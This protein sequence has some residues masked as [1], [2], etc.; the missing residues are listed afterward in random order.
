MNDRQADL[1]RFYRILDALE[2]RIGGERTLDQ[3]SGKLAWP[4]RGVY[5]FR[6]TGETRSDCGNGSRI[7][8]VGTHGLKAGSGT[9]LWTRLRPAT[10]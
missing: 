10:R 1:R 6:E 8:R 9:K 3:C 5:F 4:E 7:V 2:N